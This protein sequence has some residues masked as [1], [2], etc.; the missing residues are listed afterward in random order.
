MVRMAATALTRRPPAATSP[1]ADAMATSADLARA[2]TGRPCRD[3][4]A[5]Q[6]VGRGAS[7]HLSRQEGADRGSRITT[8]VSEDRSAA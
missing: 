7:G 2:P 6:Q 8:A 4:P 3:G 5:T 1:E